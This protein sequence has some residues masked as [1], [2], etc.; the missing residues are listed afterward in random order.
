MGYKVITQ[1]SGERA[2]NFK[3]LYPDMG[4]YRLGITV[5]RYPKGCRGLYGSGPAVTGETVALEYATTLLLQ[6]Q[7]VGHK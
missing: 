5:P 3:G 2:V 6:E 4:I 1:P 7:S